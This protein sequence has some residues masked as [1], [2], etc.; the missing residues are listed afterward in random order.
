M[1]SRR[2]ELEAIRFSTDP[3]GPADM[4]CPRCHE[5]LAIHQP[6]VERPDSLLGV[7]RGCR[8][9]FMI[10]PTAAVMARLPHWDT[11]QEGPRP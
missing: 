7:C 10:D 2:L 3:A 5:P 4:Q 6:D 9:W 11:L 8:T 1:P